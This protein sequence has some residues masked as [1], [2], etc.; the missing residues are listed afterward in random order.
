MRNRKV[1]HY[2][3]PFGYK[4]AAGCVRRA[5]GSHPA[6]RPRSAATGES[7]GRADCGDVSRLTASDLEASA[8]AAARAVGPGASRG[9]PSRLRIE[10][11]APKSG[12]FMDRRVSNVLAK[13]P[14][15]S[16]KLRGKRAIG[17]C[18]AAA[19]PDCED[20]AKEET[21]QQKRLLNRTR[22]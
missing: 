15:Q 7:A 4:W 8:F 17:R 11:R 2:A 20:K 9:A 21:W 5:L 22:L 10:C 16:E 12:R 6:L 1:T 19:P 18:K 14:G 3:S 13:E